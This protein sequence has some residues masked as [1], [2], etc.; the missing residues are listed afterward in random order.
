MEAVQTTAEL[1]SRIAREFEWS[2]GTVLEVAYYDD[3]HELVE[4]GPRLD[5]TPARHESHTK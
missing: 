2:E 4:V 5:R 1:R 3:E